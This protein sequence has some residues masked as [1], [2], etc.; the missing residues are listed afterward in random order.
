MPVW[1]FNRQRTA[2]PAPVAAPPADYPQ[3]RK[4]TLLSGGVLGVFKSGE[5]SPLDNWNGT[6][7]SAD[8]LITRFQMRLVARSREQWSNNDY[9]RAFIRLVR[10]NVVGPNGVTMQSKAKKARGGQLDKE[11]NAA[12][13]AWW[14]DWARKGNCEV[15]GQLSLRELCNLLTETTARDGEFFVR[16]IYGEDAG[17]HGFAL[18]VIDPQRLPVWYE[19]YR[20]TDNGGFIRHG[21]EFNRYGRPVAYHFSSTE[22]WDAYYYSYAGNGFVRIPAEQIIHG[23]VHEMPGQR[24]GLPWASTSLFRLHHLQGFEDAAVQNARAGATKMGFIQ[25]REGFGPEADDDV[26]VADTIEAEPL[27]FHE[28]PEGAEF[29]EFAP[30]YPNNEFATFHK[31]MLRGAAAGM[32]VLYNNMAGDLEGVNF[33]SIRQGTLD[34]REH[35]KELQQWLIE[36]LLDPV[37]REWIKYQLLAGNL[38]VRGQPVPATKLDACMCTSWQPRRWQWIDPRADV[39]AAIKSIRA[40]LTSFSQVIREQGRDPEAVFEE[41]AADIQAMKDAGIEEETILLFLLGVPPPPEP[42]AKDEAKDP[43]E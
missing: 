10:Q 29:K 18:Q 20:R 31:A 24:R 42:Q 37:F 1:P 19:N 11:L 30:Q 38:K 2:A 4:R 5:T 27:S 22:E 36:T 6:P 16:K 39:E 26:D 14:Q 35:W 33:S 3:K 12:V 17:P 32:G 13:E 7:I 41:F 28:L 8:V 23:F 9:V 21:I 40:G 15:T 43:A 25:Y 34:E